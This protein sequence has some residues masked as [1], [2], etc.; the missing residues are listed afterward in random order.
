MQNRYNRKP[1]D[2][3]K[4]IADLNER[5]KHLETYQRLSS[6]SIDGGQLVLRGGDL[7]VQTAAGEDVYRVLSGDVP[8][9]R[10]MPSGPSNYRASQFGWESE[11]QGTAF[12]QQIEQGDGSLDGGKLLL[13]QGAAYMSH[14]PE[15]LPESFYSAG[16]PSAGLLYMKGKFSNNYVPDGEVAL[17][18]GTVSIGAGASSY[19]HTYSTPLSTTPAV[20]YGLLNSAGAV[21]HSLTAN[22]TSGF[23]VAWSGTL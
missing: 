4:A 7:V 14:Q 20:V 1:P 22:S 10:V 21:T 13:M 23:T 16:V 18:T 2:L 17:V 3:I 6:T 5:I 19:S 12:Q 11:T 8:V 15:S 9:V